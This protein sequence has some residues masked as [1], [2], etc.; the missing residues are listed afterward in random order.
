MMQA[1]PLLLSAFVS[2]G[3]TPE[4]IAFFENKIRPVLVEHCYQC[5]SEEAV[6]N[7]KLRGGLKLDT[8]AATL[9][10]GDSGPSVVPGKV[11]EGHLLAAMRYN[12]DITMPPKGKLSDQIIA[13]FE[14]W[15]A[16][17][18]PDPRTGKGDA[19]VKAGID[20]AKGK[21]WWAFQPLADHQPAA[22]A[23]DAWSKT[24]IDRFILAKLAEKKI[25]PNGSASKEQLLRRLS[26][27]LLG[28]PPT[29]AEI[30]AFVNDTNA[31]AYD[32]LV[33][34]LLDSPHFGER[35]AR[36]WLDAVR[37]AESSGYE[38]DKDRAGAYHYRDFVIKAFNDDMPYDEFVRLQIAGDHLKANDFFATSAT[39][40]LVAGPY[41]GQITQKTRELIRYN[42][43]DDMISTLGSSMLGLSV[44]CARCHDHKY[45][46]LP[47]Q[48]YYRLLAALSRTDSIERKMNPTPEVFKKAKEDYDATLKKL[49]ADVAEYEKTALLPRLRDWA[50]TDAPAKQT[51][52]LTFDPMLGKLR[53]RL[54]RQGDAFGGA[55]G[56]KDEPVVFTVNTFQKNLMGLRLEALGSGVFQL[57]GIT[58]TA[59]PIVGDAKPTPLALK[60]V[61]ANVDMDKFASI[62]AKDK[63]G[64]WAPADGKA[65]HAVIVGFEQPFQAFPNGTTLTI[66]ISIEQPASRKLRLGFSTGAKLDLKGAASLQND[67]DI[68]AGLEVADAPA[69][70]LGRWHGRLDPETNQPY[71]LLDEHLGKEPKE[72][73][74]PVFSA[75]SGR[76]GDVHFLIRGEVERKNGIAQTGFIQ[77]LMK[78]KE[79]RWTVSSPGAKPVMKEPRIALA[80]WLTDTDSGAGNLLARVIVNRLWQHH[81]GRGLVATTNDFGV[82]GEAPSHPELLEYLARELVKNGWRLKPIHKLIVQ[83]AVYRESGAIQGAGQ[84]LDPQNRLYWRHAPRR[85]EAETIR[86]SVL[87]VSGTLDARSFG[88]GSLDSDQP[89]RSIYLTVK[90]SKMVAMMAMFDAPEP[91]QS[92]GERS[93]TTVP[94]QSLAF[95]N[96]TFVRGKAEKLAQRIKPKSQGELAASIAEA[97]RTALGRS[98]TASEADRMLAFVNSQSASYGMNGID[99]AMVD[100]CQI[101][102]CLNEFVY[103]D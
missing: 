57:K 97:Y 92:I 5:H 56:A 1:L 22:T 29:P 64:I 18:A 81:L 77:V 79:D 73:L 58:V 90:R 91:I 39:G 27:D 31:D 72:D 75:S 102:M 2:Q 53:G 14:A 95:L 13:D 44:G 83:S 96:S 38:F 61:A 6:K 67:L 94:T 66:A 70:I 43:L 46:P 59:Q 26:F 89:R 11:K 100:A 40:F 17:G 47:Q 36:H 50:K 41:P 9:R 76:G 32:R 103:V 28:L 80:E 52:W 37:F 84:K 20:I 3:Q 24:P 71:R 51:E 62:F 74:T 55:I 86:D 78:E 65:E 85:L 25:A 48:D 42:H 33:D 19:P 69:T 35:W 8:A 23:K 21:T 93:V 45:D 101:L 4:G 10:G 54:T 99:R 82:Q 68:R 16:M 34:R 87:A 12:G 30:D 15:I 63:K 60:P 98:P 7:K 49:T 88:P